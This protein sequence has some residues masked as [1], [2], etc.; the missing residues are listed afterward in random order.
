VNRL[1]K[2]KNIIKQNKREIEKKYKVKEIGVF[3]STVRGEEKKRSDIDILVEF[4]EP[5]G[6]FDFMELEEYLENILGGK[7]DLVSKKALKP[8]IGQYILKEVMYI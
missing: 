6:L 7:V 4:K 5:I 2:I 1:N 3:G 8:R